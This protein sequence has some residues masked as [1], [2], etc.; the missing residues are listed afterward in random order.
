MWVEMKWDFKT[1]SVKLFNVLIDMDNKTKNRLDFYYG[2]LAQLAEQL[3]VKEK[4]F[5]RF[6]PYTVRQER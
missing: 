4:V 2:S 6:E 5:R 1:I 3:P